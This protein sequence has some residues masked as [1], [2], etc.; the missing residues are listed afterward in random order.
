MIDDQ[1]RQARPSPSPLYRLRS[2]VVRQ[3][4]KSV[5]IPSVTIDSRM[6][7]PML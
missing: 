2:S 5:Q 4:Q 1:Q 3:V 6:T 7:N